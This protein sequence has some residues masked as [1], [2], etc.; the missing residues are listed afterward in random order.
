MSA[1]CDPELVRSALDNALPP[2]IDVVQVVE[3][4]SGALADRL[5]GS[6]WRIDLATSQ[7]ERLREA[8]SKFCA[9]G[10]VD[11]ERVTKN[12]V[13]TFD[14]REAVVD[15]AVAPAGSGPDADPVNPEGETESRPE[16]LGLLTRHLT[17]WSAPTMSSKAWRR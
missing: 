10:S 14:A 8:V 9:A 15:L 17:P 7:P 12:G 6:R 16:S 3:A 4:S 2:G 5:T 1:P 11:V 13:R